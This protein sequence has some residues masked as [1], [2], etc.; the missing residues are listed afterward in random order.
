MHPGYSPLVWVSDCWL[1][2][3]SYPP[4]C[5]FPLNSSSLFSS[6][7]SM[8]LNFLLARLSL[9]LLVLSLEFGFV[10]VLVL[11]RS[12]M[13]PRVLKER[14]ALCRR[15]YVAPNRAI[16]HG[17][18]NQVLQDISHLW[19]EMHS[20][21]SWG[22]AVTAPGKLVSS[23]CPQHKCLRGLAVCSDQSQLFQVCCSNIFPHLLK[24]GVTL[25]GYTLLG[26]AACP[27]WQGRH[28]KSQLSLPTR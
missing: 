27:V 4:I 9:F 6:L 2:H 13:S 21:F 26:E 19:C 20:P 15:H 16:P 10:P 25:R 24:T 1:I 28:L 12:A 23:S 14:M 7:V 18:Q 8:F 11:S 17:F 3:S 22:W 5:W